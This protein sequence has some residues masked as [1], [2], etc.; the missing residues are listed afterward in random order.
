[1]RAL[2]K[3][4]CKNYHFLTGISKILFKMYYSTTFY[5]P[6]DLPTKIVSDCMPLKIV[7][8][9]WLFWQGFCQKLYEKF[10]FHFNCN[11]F[12]SIFFDSGYLLGEELLTLGEFCFTMIGRANIKG[13]KSNVTMNACTETQASFFCGLWAVVILGPEGGYEDAPYF[14]P[15]EVLFTSLHASKLNVPLYSLLVT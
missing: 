11:V 12:F 3:T 1:M 14:D 5:D 4:F 6:K 15:K 9:I 10:K 2:S 13:S 8:I 7:K